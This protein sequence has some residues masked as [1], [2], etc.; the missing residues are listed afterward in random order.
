MDKKTLDTLHGL[1]LAPRTV[2]SDYA[3]ERAQEIGELAS[4]GLITTKEAEGSY[5][6]L[7]RINA[8]GINQLIAYGLL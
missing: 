4:Q 6:R 2:Q 5:G 1:Y 8:L 7:W 3:R